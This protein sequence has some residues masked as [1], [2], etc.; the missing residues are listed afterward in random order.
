MEASRIGSQRHGDAVL[1]RYRRRTVLNALYL[2]V[3][4]SGL[5]AGSVYVPSAVRVFGGRQG[6]N[7]VEAT[8]IASWATILLSMAPSLGCLALPPLAERCGRRWTLSR[9]L[10]S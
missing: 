2:F 8:R 7:A 3:S 5:W 6:L 9:L 1:A 4:I 10:L